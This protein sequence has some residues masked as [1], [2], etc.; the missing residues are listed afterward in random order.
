[1]G[2]NL[3]ATQAD[4]NQAMR[5]DQ[6]YEARGIIARMNKIGSYSLGPLNAI[7]IYEYLSLD[8]GP[9]KPSILVKF[10]RPAPVAPGLDGQPYIDV[11]KLKEGDIVVNP[12]FIYSRVPWTTNTMRKHLMALRRYRPKTI[13]SSFVD[14]DAKKIDLG[15]IDPKGVTKQ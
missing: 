10:D 15:V 8:C 2:E 6:G 13:L 11:S 7:P 5:S 14:K 9:G 3:D 1:M 4:I 12:G